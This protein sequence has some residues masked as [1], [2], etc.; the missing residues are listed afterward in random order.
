METTLA[1]FVTI[2]TLPYSLAAF[3]PFR[4]NETLRFRTFPYFP[5]LSRILPYSPEERFRFDETIE[6]HIGSVRG[7][8]YFPVLLGSVFVVSSKRN[9]NVVRTPRLAFKIIKG[10]VRG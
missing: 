10:G 7:H 6:N 9:A 8:P 5:V 2:C 1:V 4:Q 3:L